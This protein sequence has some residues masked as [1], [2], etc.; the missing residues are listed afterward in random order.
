MSVTERIQSEVKKALDA[1]DDYSLQYKL[2]KP[3]RQSTL[4]ND[5]LTKIKLNI[6][7]QMAIIRNA[8]VWQKYLIVKSFYNFYR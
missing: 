1:N 6:Q 5:V 3:I 4:N 7:I 2:I 8:N